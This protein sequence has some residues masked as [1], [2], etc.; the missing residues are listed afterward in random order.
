MAEESKRIVVV[1]GG[2]RGIGRSI[3]QYMAGDGTHI[4]FNYFNPKSPDVEAEMAKE[5][6]KAIADAGGSGSSTSV[7][8]VSETDV[9]AFFGGIFLE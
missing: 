9:N 8:V 2:S 4:Y 5:T 6:E 1:T 7:D 3:C